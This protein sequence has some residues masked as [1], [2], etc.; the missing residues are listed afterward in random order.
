MAFPL[1]MH[2]PRIP[3]LVASYVLSFTKFSEGGLR[4]VI[5]YRVLLAEGA[6]HAAENFYCSV[7][8]LYKVSSDGARR[9]KN[10]D[11]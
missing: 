11:G 3:L 9:S 1:A 7:F 8:L 10:S 6:L 2:I 5:T 4:P